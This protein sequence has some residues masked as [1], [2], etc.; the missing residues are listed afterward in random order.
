[1]CWMFTFCGVLELI[2]TVRLAAAI[3]VLVF[4]YFRF[5]AQPKESSLPTLDLEPIAYDDAREVF[6]DRYDE[7]EREDELLQRWAERD[8]AERA[9]DMMIDR[10]DATPKAVRLRRNSAESNADASSP[11]EVL[12]WLVVE[13]YRVLV[14]GIPAGCLMVGLVVSL[15]VQILWPI[16]TLILGVVCGVAAFAPEQRD[17]SYQFLAAQHFPLRPLWRFKILCSATA[18]VVFTLLLALGTVVGTLLQIQVRRPG[19]FAGPLFDLMG[20]TLFF[21]IWLAY[22]FGVGQIVVWLCRKNIL[23]LLLSTLIAAG[24]ITLW[25]P[26]MI[27]GG[28]NGW[29]LWA[30]PAILLLAGWCLVRAWAGGRMQERRPLLALA[31]FVA[32]A[33]AWAARRLR[34]SGV[35]ESRRRS[36]AGRGRVSGRHS[37]RQ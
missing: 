23:A 18:A 33:A 25:L 13:Q 37:A 10:D 29:Q 19:G 22:G 5:V 6:L 3:I 16:A 14:L 15:N 20:P 17:L 1:M 24:T 9:P 4:S 35:G 28:M 34:L 2:V 27:A 21:G 26:P 8:R 36:A 11:R 30:T 12:W 32:A 7:F 31:G